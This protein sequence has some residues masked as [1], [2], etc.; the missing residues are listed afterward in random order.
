MKFA[1]ELP[2]DKTAGINGA[3]ANRCS[4]IGIHAPNAADTG[5]NVFRIPVF[6][7][8]RPVRIGNHAP[9]QL[10]FRERLREVREMV[11]ALELDDCMFVDSTVLGDYTVHGH[12]PDQ[13]A[14][15]LKAMDH[16]LVAEGPYD[17]VPPIPTKSHR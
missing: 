14:D 2:V 4:G 6:C 13:K 10:T 11:A 7:F 16:L 8:S 12:L 1:R 9:R 17:V 3:L 15:M 5:T